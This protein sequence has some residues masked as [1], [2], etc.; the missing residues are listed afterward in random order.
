MNRTSYSA[1]VCFVLAAVVSVFFARDG[2]SLTSVEL[3]QAAGTNMN[4]GLKQVPCDLYANQVG[5]STGC[6]GL[7]EGDSC[8]ECPAT[9]SILDFNQPNGG[10]VLDSPHTQT[11]GNIWQGTCDASLNCIYDYPGE[12]MNACPTPT[13]DRVQYPG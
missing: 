2:R 13:A 8:N 4:Y 11:C 5:V 3:G 9:N 6:A 12:T 1:T 7:Q 10:Y